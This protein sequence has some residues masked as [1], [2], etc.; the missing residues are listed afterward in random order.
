MA[1][2]SWPTR[3]RSDTLLPPPVTHQKKILVVSIVALCNGMT[4]G[5]CDRA[6][7]GVQARRAAVLHPV[8]SAVPAHTK[9]LAGP[10]IAKKD[11]P[12]QVDVGLIGLA[13]PVAE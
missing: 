2:S 12:E 8:A 5:E 10:A 4:G 1:R 3:C 7:A 11:I 9:R 6:A 13:L